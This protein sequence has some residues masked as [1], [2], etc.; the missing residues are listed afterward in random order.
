[1]LIISLRMSLIPTPAEINTVNSL[2]RISPSMHFSVLIEK[3][4]I[5]YVGVSNFLNEMTW[6]TFLC[7]FFPHLYNMGSLSG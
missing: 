3:M 6:F 2:V 4:F 5:K 7:I 1:M